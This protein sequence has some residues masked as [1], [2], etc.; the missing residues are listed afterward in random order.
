MRY[1]FVQF[2]ILCSL[3]IVKI[4]AQTIIDS[5]VI[6]HAFQNPQEKLY[7]HTDKHSYL[8]GEII[9]F[10]AYLLADGSPSTI[11]TNLYADLIDAKG[12]IVSHKTMPILSSTSDGFFVLPD[13]SQINTYIIRAYTIWQ[14]NSDTAF[15]YHKAIIVNNNTERTTPAIQSEVNL[16]FFAEGGNM[17]NGLY[18]YIAFKA[19]QSNGLPYNLKAAVKNNNGELIDSIVTIHNGMGLFKF[20]PEQ[21]DSYTAEWKDYKGQYHKTP[22]PQAQSEGLLLHVEQIKNEL[23]YLINAPAITDNL[24][25]LTVLATINQKPV[26]SAVLKPRQNIISQKVNTQNFETG[27]LQLTVFDKNNQPLAERI[28]FINNNNYSFAAQLNIPKSSFAKRG[29]NSI[30]VAISDTVSS[31]LSL[32]VYDAD[33]EQQQSQTTIYTDLLLQADLKGYVYNAAWYFEKNTTESKQYLDLVMQTNG[34][35]RY[36]WAAVLTPINTTPKNTE[37]NYLSV[38]GKISG[39]NRQ[40]AKAGETITMILQTADSAKQWYMPISAQD[41]TFKQSGLI[42]YDTATVYYKPGN[43]KDKTL[44]IGITK[45][46]NGLAKI[47]PVQLPYWLQQYTAIDS[48]TTISNYTKIFLQ[49]IKNSKPGFE[50]TAKLLGTVTVKSG[51]WHNWKNDPMIKMDEKYTTMF[52]GIGSSYT[53]D[54]LHDSLAWAKL[55]IYNYLTAKIGGPKVQYTRGEKSFGSTLIY[56][57]ESLVDNDYL[58]NIS[59]DEIAYIKYPCGLPFRQGLCVYLKKGN[60]WQEG[61]KSMPS[62]LSKFKIEG[63]SPIKEFYSPNYDEPNPGHN[64]ADVRST[65]LWQPYIL[66][67]KVNNKAAVS[68]FNNDISKRLKIV[69]EGINEEGKLIHIEKIIE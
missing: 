4:K 43:S 16:Q 60:E 49:H 65:L 59:M 5:S 50:Q 36:N 13:T 46:Y 34:W 9:W 1:R 37:E 10:K 19:T 63:Y 69:L 23:Y 7:I 15:I 24:Q 47:Q 55:D 26:Y 38:Y 6:I 45:D 11:S 42:F 32:A 30:E 51:G 53:F 61:V 67:N 33:L 62:N 22:L 68:F 48:F 64:N 31:N 17:V 20:T 29:K 35:R 28:V 2:F 18:N 25:Q 21:N 40:G 66:L 52:R 8:P 27:I 39:G 41:G 57:N 3:L 56:V 58:R 12:N 44:G 14:F 54:V